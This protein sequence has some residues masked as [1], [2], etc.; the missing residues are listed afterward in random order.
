MDAVLANVGK[1]LRALRRARGQT[2]EEIARD[3]GYTAGYLSQIETGEATPSLAAL[4]AIA[5]SLGTEITAFFPLEAPSGVRVSRAGDPDKL[6]IAP[7]SREEYVALSARGA[8]A[9]FTALISRYYPG[10]S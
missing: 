6:R 1:R 2:L 3:T 5:A 9:S 4:A 7:N 8:N 10:D